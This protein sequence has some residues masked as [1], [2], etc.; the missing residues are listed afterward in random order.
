MPSDPAESDGA[1]GPAGRS[2]PASVLPPSGLPWRA[3]LAGRP[4]LGWLGRGWPRAL[5]AA[6][7]GIVGQALQQRDRRHEEQAAGDRAADVEQPVVVAG[8]PADEHVGEHQLD[9]LRRA[10]VADEVGAVLAVR[11]AAEGHVVPDDVDFLAVFVDDGGQRVVREGG[12]DRVVQ[13]DVVELGPADDVLLLLGGQGVP[14][15]QVM[16]VLLDDHVAAAGVRR[17]LGADHRRLDRVLAGRV[18]RPVHEADQVPVV[19]VAEAVHLV[20]GVRW[21]RPAAR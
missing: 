14:L 5:W 12:L 19:E 8:R 17:V 16:Q 20:D 13:F 7:G 9:G 2:P 6:V 21:P 18:L 3:G 11:G 15:G 1:G 4:G 10:G